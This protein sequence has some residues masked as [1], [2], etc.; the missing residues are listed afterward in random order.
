MIIREG[1]IRVLEQASIDGYV[2]ELCEHCREYAPDL[3]ESLDD[4]QLEDAVRRGMAAAEAH[5][6]DKRGPVRFYLDMMIA[7]GAGFDTDPQYPWAAEILANPDGLEQMELSDALH[8][9]ATESFNIV[10]G[11]KNS[12]SNKSLEQLLLRVKDGIEFKRENFRQDMLVLLKEIHPMKYDL[13]GED[14]LKALINYAIARG[15]D[16][17]GFKQARSMAM[18]TL[19]MFALG[20]KFDQDPFHPWVAHSLKEEIGDK[21]DEAAEI[22]ERRALTW[23]EAVLKKAKEA[24]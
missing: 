14:A 5:G 4:K 7:F 18:M 19:M 21:P 13:V 22:L 15:N 11:P 24:R 10:F 23:F 12:H 9:K 6:F 17:Y 3:L 2:A 16:R 1:Q 20:H 8:I